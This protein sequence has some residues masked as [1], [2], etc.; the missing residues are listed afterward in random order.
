MDKTG[1]TINRGKSKQDYGT[2]LVFMEA[3]KKR[4][5]PISWDLAA[6]PHNA[7][8][9]GFFSESQDSLKE[10]WHT[11]RGGLQWLNPPFFNIGDWAKKCSIESRLGANILLLIPASVGSNWFRDYVMGQSH[12]MFL[13]GRITFDGCTDPYPKD[14]MLCYYHAGVSGFETW[15]WKK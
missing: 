1:P 6:S 4:F 8:A 12:V 5:G 3:V 2:P 9:D 14:L 11:W 15:N 13:N 10:P 7:K